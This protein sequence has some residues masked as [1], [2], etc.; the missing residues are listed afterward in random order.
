MYIKNNDKKYI[1]N[2]CGKKDFATEV[3][4]VLNI[5]PELNGDIID[6][7]TSETIA[8]KPSSLLKT[9]NRN[10]YLREELV[11]QNGVY[12]LTLSNNPAPTK[13]ELEEKQVISL[14]NEKTK[15][16]NNLTKNIQNKITNGIDFQEKHF[17]FEEHDQQNLTAICQYLTAH[18]EV[19]GYLY[20]ADGENF[21]EYT[22]EFLFE[23]HQLMIEHI[24]AYQTLYHQIKEQISNCNSV[25]EVKLL[26]V[27]RV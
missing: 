12:V 8:G 3:S 1:C 15:K 2:F 26:I 18:P 13:K 22:K 24:T 16:L 19:E 11:E 7:Y 4:F 21:E 25:E 20:H 27:E 17:S 14:Q 23:L 9:I 5:K 10:D 6:I